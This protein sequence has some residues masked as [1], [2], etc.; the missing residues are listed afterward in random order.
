[1]RYNLYQNHSRNLFGFLL[2]VL[3]LSGGLVVGAQTLRPVKSAKI[4]DEV[5]SD[6]R[7]PCHHRKKKFESW[8]LS[9]HLPAKIKP[10]VPY[11]SSAF[12]AVIIKKY[13]DGCD[14]LDVNSAVETERLR[15]QKLLP[16]RKVFAEY[17]CP[18]M[19]A[20]GYDFA[21]KMDKSRQRFLY[22]DYIAVYAGETADEAK[23][24]LAELSRKF[25]KAEV[26]KMTANWQRL[27]Q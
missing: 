7:K 12:Y 1:M 21:G 20:V 6:P 17:S 26:K 15:V 24:L 8:E 3:I 27:E 23:Q 13:E 19:D 10:N 9:F 2:C 18:N 11:K 14:E 16:T 5:C 25:P 4:S 22:M